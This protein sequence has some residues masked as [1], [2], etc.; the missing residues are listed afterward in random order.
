[1]GVP[2]AIPIPQ[3]AVITTGADGD[4]RITVWNRTTK[5]KVAG[6]A[7]PMEKNLA[8]YLQR[9]P[10]CELYHGQDAQVS[11]EEKKAIIAA[12]NRIAIWN[13]VTKRRVSGNAAPSEKKLAEYLRKHPECEVYNGQDKHPLGGSRPQ[14]HPTLPKPPPS[15]SMQVP[16]EVPGTFVVPAPKSIIPEMQEDELSG[17]WAQQMPPSQM[18]QPISMPGAAGQEY[19]I[20]DMFGS[21]FSVTQEELL[22]AGS[23]GKMSGQSL[24]GML[25]GMSL[26]E[27]DHLMSGGSLGDPFAAGINFDEMEPVAASTQSGKS[28]AM[29]VPMSP[30]QRIKRDRAVSISNVGLPGGGSRPGSFGTSLT[31]SAMAHPAQRMRQGPGPGSLPKAN[32]QQGPG[33]HPG[34]GLMGGGLAGTPELMDLWSMSPGSLRDL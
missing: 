23:L 10:D 2:A 19:S 8:D 28:V 3:T 21:E 13:K 5:R 1:M 18:A 9:H 31:G 16:A 26:D 25:M 20:A 6:N 34:G 27:M 7:A 14:M 22:M 4:K 24:E 12:Q 32:L 33:S 30:A 15:M 11:P 17:G 29:S